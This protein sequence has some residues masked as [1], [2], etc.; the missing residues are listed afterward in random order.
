MP[1][2]DSHCHLAS[3]RF[4]PAEIPN[5]LDRAENAGVHRVVTLATC[6]EDLPR[7]LEIAAD[8]RVHAC[9]GIHPCDVTH[10]PDDAVDQL[11]TH[12]ADPRVCAIGETGLDYYHPAPEGW[13]DASYQQRQRDFLR[14][15]F[16]VAATA[17]LNLV[18]HTRDRN[19]RAS[20]RDALAIYQEYASAVR[21]MFHCFAGP[22]ENAKRVIAL[23]GLVSFGGPATFKNA[24]AIRETLA[25]CPAGTFLL[26]TDAPYLAPE[27][28]RGSRN[29][30]AF[31]AAT[32]ARI[33]ETRNE[34][35]E[36]L[37]T[38][39]EEACSSFFR[40]QSEIG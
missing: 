2:T 13:T 33:A 11:A 1:I 22:W 15:H 30:P 29:E 4:D 34:S 19:G 3:A 26:E 16:E 21:A 20:Y 38:H 25:R 32:A 23:G 6:L 27:P 35:P 8:P 39:T 12:T 5:L 36:I 24:T 9:I 7:N 18:I 10:A 28:H 14:R 17:K 37:S 31:T 40:F